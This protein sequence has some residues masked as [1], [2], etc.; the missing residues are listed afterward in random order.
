MDIPPAEGTPEFQ[1]W[2]DQ[3]DAVEAVLKEHGLRYFRFGRVLPRG[4]RLHGLS[5]PSHAASGMARGCP[6]TPR[7][8]LK[9][10]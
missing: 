1:E 2:Q 6:R 9:S 3:R 5:S 10:E 7:N 8:S 4:T